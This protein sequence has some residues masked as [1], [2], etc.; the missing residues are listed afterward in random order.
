ME[1]RTADVIIVGGGPAGLS[2]AMVL[3]RSC[4]KVFVFDTGNPRNKNAHKMHG[5]LSRDGDD[6]AGFLAKA[7]KE[8]TQYNVTLI[9]KEVTRGE[10]AG[11]LFKIT[12]SGNVYFSKKVLLATGLRDHLPAIQNIEKFYGK[13]VFHCPYCDGWEFRDQPWLVFA[14]GR[15]AAVEV[16]LRLR[17]WTSKITLL[18]AHTHALTKKE[19]ERL[20]SNGIKIS[21]QEAVELKGRDGYLEKVILKNGD[22][23]PAKAMLFSVGQEQQSDLAKQLK[24]NC[25]PMGRI[26]FNKLQQT[27]VEGLYVAGDMAWDMQL[28]IIAAAEGA[29]AAVAINTALNKETRAR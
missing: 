1:D 5:F 6:P 20:K 3:G 23:I 19:K 8:L 10:K 4:R 17:T 2:C 22:E 14:L 26:T 11:G 7:R 28:V 9:D 12:A 29:K 18:A 13:S 16:S 21:D 15:K 25:T 24:C 27:N